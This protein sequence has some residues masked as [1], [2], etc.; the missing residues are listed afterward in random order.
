LV[1]KLIVLAALA[2]I[3]IVLNRLAP[4][5]A[6]WHYVVPATP[7]EVLYA[8]TFDDA[9]TDW[10]LYEGRLSAQV[11]DG[12]LRVTVDEVNKSP[13][14]ASA[15]YFSDFDLRV[16]S[17]AVAGPLDNGYG[18][19]FRVQD[20]KNYY[21]FL[22]S[23]DGYYRVLRRVNDEE[24]LLSEWIPSPLVNQG[25]DAV[26]ELRVVAQGDT[27]HFYIN[28]E[29]VEL[30]IPNDPEAI[31]TYTDSCI[32]GQMLPE[33]VDSSIADGQLGVVA[34]VPQFGEPGVEVDF[35]NV[36][37]FGPASE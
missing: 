13:Y 5:V 7:G 35:D 34:H 18:V 26:N 37:V 21:L 19:V 30:C 14:S 28:G 31:S 8:A 16:Q 10:E 23:S 22:I 12:A 9:S 6:E 25:L 11:A 1:R 3:W 27:F 15:P 2:A 36:L 20:T 24:K 32:D 4:M 29:P 33:L 17:K